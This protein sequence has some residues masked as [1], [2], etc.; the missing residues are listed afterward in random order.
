[1]IQGSEGGA[2]HTTALWVHVDLRTGR[3]K[4][5]PADFDRLYGEAAAGRE[6]SARLGH[7]DPPVSAGPVP[8][9][10][11]FSDF[12]VLGHVNN[13]VYWAVVEEHLDLKAPVTV[14]LEYRGGIDR[15]QSAGVVVDGD[16]LWIVADGAVA[17]SARI[18]AEGL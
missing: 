14:V 1:S 16:S 2:I 10:A 13:A 6:V 9:P 11:R 17:A 5:L 15:G 12:D 18:T 8:W 3:P 7:D 4:R